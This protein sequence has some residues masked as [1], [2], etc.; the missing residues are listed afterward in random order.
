MKP[1]NLKNNKKIMTAA[2]AVSRFVADGAV[3]GMGGQTIGRSAMALI[4]E[5]VR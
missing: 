4:H 2:E 3:V 5:M 1:E